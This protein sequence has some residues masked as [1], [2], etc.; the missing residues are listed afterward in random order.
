MKTDNTPFEAQKSFGLGVLLKLTKKNTKGIKILTT[1]DRF[2]S[3]VSSSEL[4]HA[5]EKTIKDHNITLV[6][7]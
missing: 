1:G 4:K 7:E 6:T 3:N 5:V 2:T